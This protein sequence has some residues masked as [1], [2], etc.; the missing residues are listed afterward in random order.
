MVSVIYLVQIEPKIGVETE[1]VKDGY[2]QCGYL[3][4]PPTSRLCETW[5]VSHIHCAK[6]RQTF[7]ATD[8]QWECL[9]VRQTVRLCDRHVCDPQCLAQ[10]FSGN[11]SFMVC[12]SHI[13]W[14][15]VYTFTCLHTH[16]TH[17]HVNVSM[18]ARHSH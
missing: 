8:I 7:S 12:L 10:T 16:S 2:R 17:P 6:V 4:Q 11:V 13:Q 5:C 18:C 3:P 14:D 9:A 15:S 1:K